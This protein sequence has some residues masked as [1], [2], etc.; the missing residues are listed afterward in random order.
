MEYAVL[1]AS[2]PG[3]V[4]IIFIAFLFS[5]APGQRINY[6]DAANKVSL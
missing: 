6:K 1:Q 3:K 5:C 4:N 2:I